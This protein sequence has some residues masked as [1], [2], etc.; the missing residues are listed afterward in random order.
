MLRY[1]NLIVCACLFYPGH[2]MAKL[3]DSID[4][5]ACEEWNAKAAPFEVAERIYFVGTKG[6]SSLLIDTGS[7]LVI[8][9]GGLPQTAQRIEDNVLKL[10]FKMSDVRYL[11]SSHE[12]FD[13]AG[14]LAKLQQ[15]SGALVLASTIA[16]PYLRI[17]SLSD[18]DPQAGFGVSA[19]YPAIANVQGYR[20]G[21]TL[22]LGT[23]QITAHHTPAHSPGSVSWQITQCMTPEAC[24]TVLYADS[25]NPVSAPDFRFS[26]AKAR[27][28][29]FRAA[30]KKVH[31]LR[32]DVVISPH[33]D[34]SEL[35]TR[36]KRS[37]AGRNL[38]AFRDQRGCA[39]PLADA[40]A[41]RLRARLIDER[42]K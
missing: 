25:L 37:N 13:H 2:A 4:C 15:R 32:C 7:G 8:V 9:D 35:W 27:V 26:D 21:Q 18:N 10:G 11:L 30:L 12:H 33:P 40:A 39:G 31:T 29:A 36:Y 5:D 19:D 20:D 17:G 3:P 41:K 6:L 34:Q 42:S 28:K 16:A 22:K 14:G 23:V 24:V 1:A 38:A